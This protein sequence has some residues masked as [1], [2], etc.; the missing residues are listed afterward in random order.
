MKVTGVSPESPSVEWFP[1]LQ[2]SRLRRWGPLGGLI[3]GIGLAVAVSEHYLFPASLPVSL[4]EWVFSAGFTAAFMGGIFG[5][6]GWIF[7]RQEPEHIGV[8]ALGI[9]QDAAHPTPGRPRLVRWNEM[10]SVGST[11]SIRTVA[12][13]VRTSENRTFRFRVEQAG[14]EAILRGYEIF[15]HPTSGE[16]TTGESPQPLESRVPVASARLTGISGESAAS[17]PMDPTG[18]RWMPNSLR[19]MWTIPGILFV[20]LGVVLLALFWQVALNPKTSQGV[21][22]LGLPIFVGLVMAIGGARF[23]SAVALTGVG[24]LVR[25][26]NGITGL[27]FEEITAISTA[28]MALECTVSSGRTVKFQSLGP[29]EKRL[30]QEAYQT[31][32]RGASS[33]AFTESSVGWTW[34]SNPVATGA[35]AAFLIPLGIFVFAIV[36]VAPLAVWQPGVY[37]SDVVFIPLAGIPATFTLFTIGPYRR[38]PKSVGFS[39]QGLMVKY[40]HNISPSSALQQLW[41][42]DVE[43][44][45][46]RHDRIR[47][48]SPDPS[49]LMSPG[50]RHL[51]IR[52]RTGIT[53]TLGP[54][55][56]EI[57]I[58][59]LRSAPAGIVVSR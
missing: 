28:A 48:G 12:V 31:Y 27:R 53:Y 59:I 9:H 26:R 20:A 7:W 54:I 55:S 47:D 11:D 13:E 44:I 33:P 14:V 5:L 24:F 2:K 30:I 43:R 37:G 52:T 16:A 46:G 40:P 39:D 58:R 6:E 56:S 51:T 36:V 42:S 3:F 4:R 50:N 22:F 32:R 1:N 21:I 34:L 45:S 15:R 57:A 8:S 19:R 38:A 10:D 17:P 35:L 18:V 25:D 23:P 29:R 41:W 49:I